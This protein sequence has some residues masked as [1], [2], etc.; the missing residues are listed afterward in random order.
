MRVL[1]KVQ[2]STFVCVSR[3]VSGRLVSLN[4][5]GLYHLRATLADTHENL[6]TTS[7]RQT[8]RTR[9]SQNIRTSSNNKSGG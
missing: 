5:N 9:D 3:H 8:P 7:D 1:L 6:E 2:M 4:H